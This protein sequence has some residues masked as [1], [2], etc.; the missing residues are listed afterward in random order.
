MK[1]ALTV[2]DPEVKERA[3]KIITAITPV[4]ASP[5]RPV[6]R[7]K[8]DIAIPRNMGVIIAPR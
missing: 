4:K 8:G 5:N 6:H 3:R 7:F 2:D 1:K